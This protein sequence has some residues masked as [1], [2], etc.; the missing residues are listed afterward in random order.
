MLP[1]LVL[2]SWPQVIHVPWPPKIAGILVQ[3]CYKDK[4]LLQFPRLECSGAILSHC[5]LNLSGLG[6]SPTSASQVAGSTGVCHHTWLIFCTFSGDRILPCCPGLPQ[7]P[8]F[9]QSAHLGL[10][11]LDRSGVISTHGNLLGSGDSPASASQVAGIAGAHHHAR[12]IFVLLVETGFH[13]VGQAGLKLLTSSDPAASASQSAGITG[14]SHCAWPAKLRLFPVLGLECGGAISAHCNLRLRVQRWVGFCHGGQAGLK[15]LT[16]GDPPASAK[17]LGLQSLTLSPRLECSGLISAH[18]NHCLLLGSS[19]SPASASGVA[20]ITGSCSVIQAG[21]QWCCHSSLQPQFP[22]IEQPP[23]HPSLSSSWDYR[24]VPPCLTN[25]LNFWRVE[26]SLCYPGWSETPGLKVSLCHLCW[27]VMALSWLTATSASQVQAIL[28]PQP[29]ER[30]SL[31]LLPRLECCGTIRAHYSLKL[32]GSRN[33]P[34]SPFQPH[35]DLAVG[36]PDSDVTQP[37]LAS[38]RNDGK[39]EDKTETMWSGER[40][41]GVLGLLSAHWDLEVGADPRDHTLSG[42]IQHATKEGAGRNVGLCS[43]E[44]PC[45]SPLPWCGASMNVALDVGKISLWHRNLG[46]DTG[47][48]EIAQD[49]ANFLHLEALWKLDVS[50]SPTSERD[51]N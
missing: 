29:L 8:G 32:L 44:E 6:D 40:G 2:N 14:G 18:Y 21:V 37:Q 39:E 23:S 46:L 7:T 10:S 16:S 11:K 30:L 35:L 22:R 47:C 5:C 33:P 27:S 38:V 3:V 9:K 1:R 17:V 51:G 24:H 25:F 20:G 13:H 12:L 15:L 26:V 4:V 36:A 41:V 19:E 31:D 48:A 42:R 49:F 34:T 45:P 43:R 28:L 50:C